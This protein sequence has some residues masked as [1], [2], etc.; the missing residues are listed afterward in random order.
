MANYQVNALGQR[1]RKIHAQDDTVYHYD[2]QGHLIA[3]TSRTGTVLREY[4]YLED[5][6][7]AVIQ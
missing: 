5:N 1:I 3:E 6:P 4:I 2:A 7:V